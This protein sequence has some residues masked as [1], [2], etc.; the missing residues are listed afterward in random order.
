MYDE[1]EWRKE[2]W[3]FADRQLCRLFLFLKD[4][5]YKEIDSSNSLIAC[6]KSES[7]FNEHTLSKKNWSEEHVQAD[8]KNIA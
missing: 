3:G 5:K 1:R 8:C 7:R 2:K 6:D 4:E